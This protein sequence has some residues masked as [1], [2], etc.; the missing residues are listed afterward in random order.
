MR[1]TAQT[2]F[3]LRTLLYLACHDDRRVTTGEVAEAYDISLNHLLKVVR[4]LAQLGY[5]EATRGRDGGLTLARPLEDVRVGAIVR[6]FEPD[7]D[8]VECFDPDRDLCVISP[9]CGLKSALGKALD[10]FLAELDAVTLAQLATE[11]RQR[12]L[13]RHLTPSAED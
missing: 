9:V 12:S 7:L 2:D 4:R 11:R 13:R 1:I 3:A 6:D 10:A 5:V 8:L